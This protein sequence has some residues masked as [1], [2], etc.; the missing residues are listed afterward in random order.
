MIGATLRFRSG[1]REITA[2]RF[3]AP[4][5]GARRPAVLLLHGADGLASGRYRLA[6]GLVAAAGY[7]VFLV[8]YLDRTGDV[9]AGFSAI[10]QRFPLWT[11][12]VRDAV[13]FAAHQPGVAPE[14][15]GIIGISLGAAL[16]LQVAAGDPRI[17]ALVAYYGFVPRGLARAGRLPPTLVL[18]GARDA[19]VPV[20]N[21]RELQA[22][23]ER[24][25]VPHEVKIYPDQ[26]HG[27]SMLAEMDAGQRTAAFLARH[28]AEGAARTP[29][30][31]PP[32][33]RA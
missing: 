20:S 26:A 1:D 18:H 5:G 13:A 31:A 7:D 9:W 6:A 23:L 17:R 27:F 33:P 14:R 22:I 10:G 25:G 19:V 3:A 21:A 28:L 32:E 29:A 12:A 8:H 30:G 11:G 2:E 16:G 15:V 24:Q 4:F